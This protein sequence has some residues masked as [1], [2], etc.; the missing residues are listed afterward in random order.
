MSLILHVVT[1][2]DWSIWI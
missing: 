2:P 1:F